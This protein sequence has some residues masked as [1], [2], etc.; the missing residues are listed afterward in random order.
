MIEL[1]RDLLSEEQSLVQL[2]T[3]PRGGSA[4]YSRKFDRQPSFLEL[5]PDCINCFLFA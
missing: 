5:I 3:E 2:T 4:T 1:M